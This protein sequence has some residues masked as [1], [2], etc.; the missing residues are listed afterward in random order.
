LSSDSFSVVKPQI[1][2]EVIKN[3]QFLLKEKVKKVKKYKQYLMPLVLHFGRSCPSA[4]PA[5]MY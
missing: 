4:A 2:S 1:K 3:K 5:N